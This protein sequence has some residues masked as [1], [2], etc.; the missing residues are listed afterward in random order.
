MHAT[1]LLREAPAG[2][3]LVRRPRGVTHIYVGP[4]TPSGRMVP[5]ASGRAVCRQRTRRLYVV[6]TSSLIP[7]ACRRCVAVVC[8]GTL[9]TAT[10]TTRGQWLAAYGDLTP[11]D[12]AVD[13][14]LA[15]TPEEVD[16][17][18]FLALLI[19]GWPAVDRSPVVAPSGR[20]TRPLLRH[21]ETA[22]I[23]VGQLTDRTLRYREQ[24]DAEAEAAAAKEA[25][26]IAAIRAHK[27]SS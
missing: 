2:A 24:V 18:R 7:R 5:E 4:L 14:W 13:A 19:V 23:R 12:L 27:K 17:V 10:P 8:K 16:R 11:F 20:T 25:R 9:T 6:D 22:R 15:E 1:T 21:I 26:V 3:V